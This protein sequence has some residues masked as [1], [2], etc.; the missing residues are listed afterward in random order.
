VRPSLESDPT[1]RKLIASV[2]ALWWLPK[3]LT[4]SIFPYSW[5]K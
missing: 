4:T 1:R 3:T 2:E 5:W